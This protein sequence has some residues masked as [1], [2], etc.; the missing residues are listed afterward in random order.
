MRI[1]CP[2]CNRKFAVSEN[3]IILDYSDDVDYDD[4]EK[5]VWEELPLLKSSFCVTKKNQT[6]NQQ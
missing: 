6:W 4:S 1:K 3:D 5:Y 2:C